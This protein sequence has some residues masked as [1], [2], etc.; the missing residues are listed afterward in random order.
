MYSLIRNCID[1]N[2]VI[3]PQTI[4]LFDCVIDAVIS[5][6]QPE[7]LVTNENSTLPVVLTM[8]DLASL[9][10]VVEVTVTDG[11]AIGTE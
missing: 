6:E 3:Q 2:I 4:Y 7:Y 9:D 5:L 8:S 10:V 11:T 1:L